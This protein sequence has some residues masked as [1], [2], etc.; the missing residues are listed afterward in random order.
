M[1]S[2]LRF[3]TYVDS[4][5]VTNDWIDCRE[6]DVDRAVVAVRE[7]QWALVD[8]AND[9]D[10]VWMIEVYDPDAAPEAQYLRIGTDTS[11]VEVPLD[12]KYLENHPWFKGK[13]DA[14]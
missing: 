14:R 9:K 4:A 11:M 13:A 7:Y 10:K 6:P 12:I 8:L 5:L 1:G 2:W 3:R